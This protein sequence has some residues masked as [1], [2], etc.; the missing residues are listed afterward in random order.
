V[1]PLLL[2]R[3]AQEELAEA[4]TFYERRLRGLGLEFAEK[5]QRAFDRIQREPQLFPFH[6]STK[7]QR[8]VV[9]RF[10][11]VIFYRDYSDRLSIVAIAHA[12]RRPDYWRSRQAD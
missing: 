8:F 7:L 10:P 5:I 1:K 6:K 11:Y 3:D 2:H 12:K 4:V 9:V